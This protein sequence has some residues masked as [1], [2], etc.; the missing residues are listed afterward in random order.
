MAS[1]SSSSSALSAWR[2]KAS[3]R[4]VALAMTRDHAARQRAMSLDDAADTQQTEFE[5]AMSE[6]PPTIL[7]MDDVDFA[8][9]FGR[10][11]TA[12]DVMEELDAWTPVPLGMPSLIQRIS[13][14]SPFERIY[15]LLDVAARITS[16]SSY[17]ENIPFPLGRFQAAS[18]AK[19]VMLF[20]RMSGEALRHIVY[21][22]LMCSLLRINQYANGDEFTSQVWDLHPDIIDPTMSPDQL[23]VR[24]RDFESAKRAFTQELLLRAEAWGT[25]ITELCVPLLAK[26][27]GPSDRL[28]RFSMRAMLDSAYGY[29]RTFHDDVRRD[30]VWDALFASDL[31]DREVV[32]D[33]VESS[34][35]QT[36]ARNYMIAFWDQAVQ[37][38]QNRRLQSALKLTKVAVRELGIPVAVANI[39]GM[40]ADERI[41]QKNNP[42]IKL[43]NKR[44]LHE[45]EERER[46]TP[47]AAATAVGSRVKMFY[48]PTRM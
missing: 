29:L 41:T 22:I 5:Q 12:S 33:V 26:F 13:R 37:A 7:K 32:A 25:F 34:D 3:Q 6:L 47:A 30:R 2:G 9:D 48:G 16:S 11:P 15:L 44:K 36:D 8:S 21:A 42:D 20:E 24:R 40:Y 31:F 18:L 39:M 19:A 1:A 45:Q 35:I 14:M 43:T 23:R 38:E 27:D 46:K 10:A 4:E 28:Q 17:W